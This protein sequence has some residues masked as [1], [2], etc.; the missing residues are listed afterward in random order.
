VLFSFAQALCRPSECSIQSRKHHVA[1]QSTLSNCAS[2][3]SAVRVLY[4]IEVSILSA[5]RVLYPIAASTL[6]AVRV[7][8]PTA[9]ASCRPSE[10]SIQSKQALCQPSEYS[11]QLR[12]HSVGRQNA[13]RRRRS[14]ICNDYRL[15][16]KG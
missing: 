12:K 13:I 9:Q 7:L 3:L 4:L 6:S 15:S 16:D 2:I 1:R 11:I 5:V 10:Y 14:K 8:Y